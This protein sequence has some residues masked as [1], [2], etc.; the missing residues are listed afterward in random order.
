MQYVMYTYSTSCSRITRS[1][2]L[3]DTTSS[4]RWTLRTGS[5]VWA[6]ISRRMAP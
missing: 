6:V 4:V 5:R 1:I 3:Q 2:K